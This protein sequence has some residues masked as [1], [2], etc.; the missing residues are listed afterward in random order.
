MSF[1]N[2]TSTPLW[3][4]S[5]PLWTPSPSTSTTT[6][7]TFISSTPTSELS[8]HALYRELRVPP[9]PSSPSL[10]DPSLN[11]PPFD[12]ILIPSPSSF[13]HT[14]PDVTHPEDAAQ[15]SR[16]LR[17][18]T[19]VNTLLCVAYLLVFI[20]GLLG[21]GCVIGV[22]FRCSRMRSPTN[23]FIANLALADILVLIFC[24]PANLVSNIFYRE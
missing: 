3:N 11:K 21:N 8:H 18:G 7:A 13:I 5:S 14:T 10:H 22:V 15:L 16:L 2:W 17:H 12:P 23:F 24:L 19:T 20:G 9:L 4:S 1:I 6:G